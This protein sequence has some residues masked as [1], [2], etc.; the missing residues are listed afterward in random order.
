MEKS[1]RTHPTSSAAVEAIAK[2]DIIEAEE[3]IK[4]VEAT[5]KVEKSPSIHDQISQTQK[6]I[7]DVQDA[8]MSNPH[9]C[10]CPC[11]VHNK[12]TNNYLHQFVLDLMVHESMKFQQLRRYFSRQ[13]EK[14]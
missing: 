4:E 14:N 3:I 8:L 12:H 6:T 10:A 5:P 9:D 1:T 7:V 2:K 13:D 11:C